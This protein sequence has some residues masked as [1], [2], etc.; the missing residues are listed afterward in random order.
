MSRDAKHGTA[1]VLQNMA[2][3]CLLSSPH[4]I[5]SNVGSEMTEGGRG[6][7]L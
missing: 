7:S 1:D 6:E 2:A 5:D 3:V 4:W